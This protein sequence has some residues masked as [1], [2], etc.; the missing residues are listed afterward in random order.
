MIKALKIQM[1][2]IRMA[3]ASRMAYRIDFFIS[4]AITLA[5]DSIIPLVTLL[6][7]NS[8]VSLPGW[9]MYEVLLIQGIFMVSK[10]IVFSFFFGIVWNT[11]E[12]VKDGTFDLVLLKPHPA[13]HLIMANAFYCDNLGILLG[14]ITL[15]GIALGNLGTVSLLHFA[16]FALLLVLSIL[17]LLSLAL[18]MAATEF[19][20]VGNSRVDEIFDIITMF[21]QYPTTIFSRTFTN[22]L[23]WIIPVSMIA[24]MPTSALLG[25]SIN[26]LLPAT[27][28]TAVLFT[29]SMFFWHVMKKIYTSA[30]G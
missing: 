1:L 29:L 4:T 30:G 11:L 10:G 21:G 17:V 23:T 13:M 28:A 22:L 20:W 15:S 9:S 7:Y 24:F 6:I 26:S 14:G 27:L 19:K 8:G 18:I 16:V 25:R 3:F 2:G 12:S 5:G